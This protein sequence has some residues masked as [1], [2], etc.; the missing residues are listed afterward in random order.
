MK[1]DERP[2]ITAFPMPESTIFSV[3]PFLGGHGFA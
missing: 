1:V 2:G 3:K